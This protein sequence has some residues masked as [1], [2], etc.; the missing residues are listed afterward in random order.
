MS[1]LAL[2]I[3]DRNAYPKDDGP[4]LNADVSMMR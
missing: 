3:S 2:F 4:S 1:P